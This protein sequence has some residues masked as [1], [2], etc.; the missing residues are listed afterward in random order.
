[1]NLETIRHHIRRRVEERR[2]R[3]KPA[4]GATSALP[5]PATPLAHAAENSNRP[6]V[7]APALAPGAEHV[8]EGVGNGPGSEIGSPPPDH[9]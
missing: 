4:E 8:I 1:M 2:G 5:A 7:E 9:T 3:P 6:P